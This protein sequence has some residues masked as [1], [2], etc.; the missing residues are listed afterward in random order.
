MNR[1]QYLFM[2]WIVRI[3]LMIQ[4][5]IKFI[6]YVR[7]SD[8]KT[9]I[10]SNPLNNCTMKTRKLGFSDIKWLAYSGISQQSWDL[11][12]RLPVSNLS[13]RRN[14]ASTQAI[15]IEKNDHKYVLYKIFEIL[16]LKGNSENIYLKYLILQMRQYHLCSLWYSIG[17]FYY[18]LFSNILLGYLQVFPD[19]PRIKQIRN[20]RKVKFQK[21]MD[22]LSKPPQILPLR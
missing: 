9:C 21:V 19:S 10:L 20:H 18:C 12:P 15:L 8:R 16:E 7:Y 6:R 22:V 1:E 3:S 13:S 5:Q 11:N 2:V 17:Y 14:K 4:L